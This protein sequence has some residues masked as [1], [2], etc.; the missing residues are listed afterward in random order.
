MTK[1]LKNILIIVGI[2]AL[3]A[4]VA[5]FFNKDSDRI[6][7]KTEKVTYR[8]ITEA[9]AASGKIQP[10]VDVKITSQVSG[11]IVVLA[12]KEGDFV[13][14]GQLLL[15]INPDLYQAALNRAQASLNSSKSGL[16]N[17]KARKVQT[18]AR[19]HADELSHLRS[20]NLYEKGAISQADWDNAQAK[21]AISKAELES[22]IENVKGAE[23]AI[24]SARATVSEAAENLSRT[25]ILAPKSGVITALSKELGESVLGNQMMA[26]EVIMKVSDLKT[27]E[28]DVEVNES[29][30]VKVSLGDSAIIEVDSYGDKIFKG[31]VTE[32]GNT[33]LNT[34]DGQFSMDAVTNFSVKIRMDKKS[35]QGLSTSAETSPFRPGMSATVEINTNVKEHVL[36]IPIRAV[37]T[38][39]DTTSSKNY[40]YIPKGEREELDPFV[41]AFVLNPENNTA[42][43]KIIK[44][45]IQDLD[46]YEILEGISEGDEVIVGPFIAVSKKLKNGQKVRVKEKKKDKKKNKKE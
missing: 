38:R 4:L 29:D 12:V 42:D 26:G 43:L 31:I 35:Y 34:M 41:V 3:L 15:K 36:A 37:T 11:Q 13:E 22:A 9:V 1:T 16:A 20:K 6:A 14:K 5:F 45:G 19:F 2:L 28:V 30:I 21:F 10:E 25:T 17:A 40:K 27:M 8:K 33:A 32:I 24:M 44:T 18:Q 23:Y 7:V 39:L 46:Y